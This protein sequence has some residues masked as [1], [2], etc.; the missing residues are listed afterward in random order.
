M[1]RES[2][3]AALRA[4]LANIHRD[5]ADPANQTPVARYLRSVA[6]MDAEVSLGRVSATVN[7]FGILKRVRVAPEMYADLPR[8]GRLVRRAV[9]LAGNEANRR[10]P[11]QSRQPGVELEPPWSPTPAFLGGAGTPAEEERL[12]ARHP[13]G[14]ATECPPGLS[15]A[16]RSA[17][18]DAAHLVRFFIMI[19]V[20]WAPSELASLLREVY[21][22]LGKVPL[23]ARF[24]RRAT[25]ID[26]PS[27]LRRFRARE[28]VSLTE[29]IH[30]RQME[31]AARMTHRSDLTL[32]EI[33]HTF[34]FH[35][36]DAITHA[37]RY[38]CGQQSPADLRF[39]WE[40]AGIDYVLLRWSV[41]GS[42]TIEQMGWVESELERM[43][44]RVGDGVGGGGR[45][46][47]RV[48]RLRWVEGRLRVV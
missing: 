36:A 8:L 45:D 20:R 15:D 48:R 4:Q 34:G 13:E 27:C 31:V 42:A 32:E 3:V 1:S 11:P 10:L 39:F 41:A 6:A 38:R 33:A 40:R 29:Y 44:L 47:E 37:I 2:L 18:L 22:W 21:R 12:C 30:R 24:V 46:A 25:G 5:L 16:Q 17:F 43:R 26:D 28:G 7:G 14:K 35:T 19:D 23:S 9:N